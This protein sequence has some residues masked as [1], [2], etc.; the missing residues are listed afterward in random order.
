MNS[1]ESS[2]LCSKCDNK[3]YLN[4]GKTGCLSGN[5]ANC[6]VYKN[7]DGSVCEACD[8]GYQMFISKKQLGGT[9]VDYYECF[10]ID[11]GS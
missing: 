3:Y 5:V 7:D 10:V 11:S 4:S 1:T 8:E 6:N 9:M 2:L